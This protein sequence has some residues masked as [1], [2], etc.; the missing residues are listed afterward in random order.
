MICDTTSGTG[1]LGTVVDAGTGVDHTMFHDKAWRRRNECMR[2]FIVLTRRAQLIMDPI[3]WGWEMEEMEEF[4][5][6]VGV[7]KNLYL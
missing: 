2:G 1:K 4:F 3:V 6:M 7:Y 5:C